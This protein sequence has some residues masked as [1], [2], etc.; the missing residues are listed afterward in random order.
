VTFAPDIRVSLVC[1]DVA[2][3][4][5]LEHL[6]ELVRVVVAAALEQGTAGTA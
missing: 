4:H 2:E 6:V 5:R 1:S 3:R